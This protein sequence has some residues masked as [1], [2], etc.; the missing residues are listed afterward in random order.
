MPRV[1]LH[2]NRQTDGYILMMVPR[3]YA[4]MQNMS[5][6][7][8]V[9]GAGEGPHPSFLISLLRMYICTCGNITITCLPQPHSISC[10]NGTRTRN[11]PPPLLIVC[12]SKS[13]I[14]QPG[15]T[16]GAVMKYDIGY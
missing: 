11:M 7:A 16:A 9:G 13:R 15:L 14:V 10:R 3:M 4:I 2:A 8:L 5:F 6:R 1:V 12:V